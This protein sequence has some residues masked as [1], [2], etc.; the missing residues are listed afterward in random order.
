MERHGKAQAKQRNTRE[1]QGNSKIA[2][3]PRSLLCDLTVKYLKVSAWQLSSGESFRRLLQNGGRK[4]RKS[5]RE[6][7]EE[8]LHIFFGEEI[9]GVRGTQNKKTTG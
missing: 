5:K 2:R 7:F 6:L 1:N 9:G 3:D 8:V 4:Q